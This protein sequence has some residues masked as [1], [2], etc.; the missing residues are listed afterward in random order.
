VGIETNAGEDLSQLTFL[1]HATR[2]MEIIRARQP[3]GPYYLGGWCSSG[4]LAHAMASQLVEA[5][6][7]V[8]LVVMLDAPNPTHYFKI[9]KQRLLSSKAA[10][11]LRR[12]LRTN[13]SAMLPYAWNRARG[14]VKQLFERRSEVDKAFQLSPDIAIM[15]YDPQPIRARV[16]VYQPADRPEVWDLRRSWAPH[17]REG[18]LEV[19]EV[20][21]DH[22]TMFEEPNVNVLAASIKKNLPGS[23]AEI[24]RAVA[25]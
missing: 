21:G 16:L 22:L 12:L 11:H 1:E 13:L 3:R 5:G 24:R 2:L 9:S 10:Y 20:P 18:N 23:N 4:L 17:I 7:K 14:F 19:H 25:S 6:E 8:G 15:T